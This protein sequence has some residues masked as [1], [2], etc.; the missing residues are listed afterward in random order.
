MM[1]G[2]TVDSPVLKVFRGWDGD[3]STNV[4]YS[5]RLEGMTRITANRK[6]E[7]LVFGIAPPSVPS[8]ALDPWW[9]ELQSLGSC[10]GPHFVH[11]QRSDD[12]T[13]I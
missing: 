4:L 12:L 11:A 13:L 8:H 1:K 7:Q 6:K 9:D 3:V 2:S 5:K 10:C